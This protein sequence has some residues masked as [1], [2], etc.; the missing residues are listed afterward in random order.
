MPDANALN[1][2]TLQDAVLGR[3][4]PAASQRNNAKRWIATAYADVWNAQRADNQLWPFEVV[5]LS[6]LTL[7]AG[8]STPTMPADYA[9]TISLFDPLTGYALKRLPTE[10][11]EWMSVDPNFSGT[12][13]VYGV[14]NRQIIL[15]P[16]PTGGTLR[17]TY[18]RRLAHKESD[19]VTV[20]AGFFDEDSDYPIWDDYHS[21]LIPRATAIGLL[22]V[23]DPTWE[24]PQAEYERQ[25]DRMKED[26]EAVRPQ[27]QW[28]AYEGYC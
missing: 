1:Y 24:T 5:S 9:D 4:F 7:S 3:R 8:D 2:L 25:L 13:Y 14:Q 19:G 16:T 22:E 26:Y 21:I 27:E 12:P 10:E 11:I 18:R 28:A 15:A 23:N 6:T 17:H 20:T